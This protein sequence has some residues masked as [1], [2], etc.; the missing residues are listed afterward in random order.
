MFAG[1]IAIY[2]ITNM[3]LSLPEYYAAI[4]VIV[5]SII[6]PLVAMCIV[7]PIMSAVCACRELAPDSPP[8][9]G[10]WL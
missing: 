9:Y 7:F 3:A 2:A 5:L 6:S 8:N 4:T 1:M 10:E